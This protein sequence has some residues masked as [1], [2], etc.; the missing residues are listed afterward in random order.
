MPHVT[1]LYTSNLEADADMPALCRRLA[2]TMIAARDEA[3]Q[4]VFPVGGVRVYAHPSTH[5]AVADGS[6]DDHGFV[7]IN[8]RMARG[9]SPATQRS[10]GEALAEAT[11]AHFGPLLARR[12]FGL[13]LQVDEGPEVYD[14]KLG[15]LHA[16]FAQRAKKG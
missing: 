14:A 11:R 13:T 8:L 6:S 16:H 12:A 15:N 5:H 4:P 7:Y 2:D 1:I 10:V 9:R 3:G